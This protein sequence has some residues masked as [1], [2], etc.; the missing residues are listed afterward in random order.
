MKCH[1]LFCKKIKEIWHKI[2]IFFGTFKDNCIS[3][4][5]QQYLMY[6]K[7]FKPHILTLFVCSLIN[8]FT[9]VANIA[10]IMDPVSLIRVHTLFSVFWRAFDFM[11]QTLYADIIFRTRNID[12]IRVKVIITKYLLDKYFF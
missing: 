10:I 8:L 11:Q 2:R 3:T 12:R 6:P 4:A 7:Y 5:P 9:S 1:A